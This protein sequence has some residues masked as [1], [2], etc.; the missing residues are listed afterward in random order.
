VRRFRLVVVPLITVAVAAACNSFPS[1][2]CGAPWSFRLATRPTSTSCTESTARAVTE[3]EWQR[4][5][6]ARSLPIRVSRIADDG[7]FQ[8]VTANGVPATAMASIPPRRR[9]VRSLIEAGRSL[10]SG[11]RAKWAAGLGAADVSPPP[12]SDADS[13]RSAR[14]GDTFATFCSRCHA[15]DGRG[16]SGAAQSSTRPICRS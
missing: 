3:R 2:H 7:R 9:A 8:R 13:R 10:V 14:G 6:G 12:Y 15:A 11:I 5:R 1:N 16:G 4:R